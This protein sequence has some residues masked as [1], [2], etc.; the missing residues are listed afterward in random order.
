MSEHFKKICKK[1][2]KVIEQCRCLGPYKM[3]TYGICEK[4]KDDLYKDL[5]EDETAR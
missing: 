3:I 5:P 2:E 4:C 1:C